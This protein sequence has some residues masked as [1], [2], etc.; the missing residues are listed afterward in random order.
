MARRKIFLSYQ[1]L[2]QLKAKGFNLMRYNQKLGLE[3]VTRG[4]LDP[5]K[6]SD[7]GYISAQIRSALKGTSVT[8]V[9]LGDKTA[10]S[11]WVNHEIQWSTEKDP[12]NGL[13]GIKLSPDAQVPDGLEGAEI[14]NWDSPQD[15]RAFDDA[16]ERAAIGA[17]RMADAQALV[18]G[19]G[20]S[21]GR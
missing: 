15:V 6:S 1:H 3:F 17:R 14:L 10:D 13:L 7:P 12:P 5:V 16:I 20:S 19:A 11:H 4:L 9:L 8:V 21:C 18:G 2:D